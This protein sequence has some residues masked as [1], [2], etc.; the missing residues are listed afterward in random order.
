MD[1]CN[2]EPAARKGAAQTRGG[3]LLPRGVVREGDG[4]QLGDDGG[5]R[6]RSNNLH[7]CRVDGRRIA[8]AGDEG[9]PQQ[10]VADDTMSAASGGEGCPQHVFPNGIS[11]NIRGHQSVYEEGI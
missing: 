10:D 8:A 11:L 6:Q 2:S 5:W 4:E 9:C 1:A 3:L 7:V